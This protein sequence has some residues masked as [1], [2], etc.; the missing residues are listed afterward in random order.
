MILLCRS[1]A[2]SAPHDFSPS[3]GCVIG[4]EAGF[5]RSGEFGEELCRFRHA[6]QR[7]VDPFPPAAAAG[8]GIL[9]RFAEAL[10][11]LLGKETDQEFRL[12]SVLARLGARIAVA[13]SF[14]DDKLVDCEA[15]G[16]RHTDQHAA[17]INERRRD[18]VSDEIVEVVKTLR[19]D[20]ERGQVAYALI[21]TEGRCKELDHCLAAG[22]A[23]FP[24]PMPPVERG[25]G[26]EG[27]VA[28]RN[29]G[30]GIDGLYLGEREGKACEPRWRSVGLPRTAA[31]SSSS[32]RSR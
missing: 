3:P 6:G 17:A 7:A 2:A 8:A 11:A 12:E 24:A 20:A 4:R 26:L 15:L 1:G 14:G 10:R 23:P 13:A 31:T 22:L 5:L 30:T 27:E 32:R 25:R 9:E 16:P 29:V 21:V 28:E 19:R 18:R